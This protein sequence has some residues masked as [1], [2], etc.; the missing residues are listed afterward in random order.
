MSSTASSRA[1]A[2]SAASGEAAREDR[3]ALG[4]ATAWVWPVRVVS[5]RYL[6]PAVEALAASAVATVSASAAFSAS[7]AAAA[8]ASAALCM[9]SRLRSLRVGFLGVL[10]ESRTRGTKP[11]ETLVRVR[12][13]V[14]TPCSRSLLRAGTTG[15]EPVGRSGSSATVGT[16]AAMRP[17]AP[18][19]GAG[20]LVLVSV[21]RAWS[22]SSALVRRMAGRSAPHIPRCVSLVMDLAFFSSDR[23]LSELRVSVLSASFSYAKNLPHE[24]AE[25]SLHSGV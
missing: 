3:G 17:K 13:R 24:F 25:G 23:C 21:R 4:S 6:R 15:T 12:T 1:A 20:S 8:S 9:V 5:V 10:C 7:A 16:S 18:V 11:V 2:R 22:S 19:C 14:P